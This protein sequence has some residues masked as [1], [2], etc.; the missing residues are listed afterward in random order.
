[1]NPLPG[2]V[3]QG[4]A[5]NAS[6]AANQCQW[7]RPQFYDGWRNQAFTLIESWPT[8]VNE[9]KGIFRRFIQRDSCLDPFK[10]DH[11]NHAIQSIADNSWPPFTA[12]TI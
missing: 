10:V 7:R 6:R 8:V 12:R 1:M 5:G 9:F 4:N 3:P 2:G 11:F